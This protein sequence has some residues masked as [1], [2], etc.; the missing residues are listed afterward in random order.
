M[1]LSAPLSTGS[2]NAYLLPRH[3]RQHH[4]QSRYSFCSSRRTAMVCL[5]QQPEYMGLIFKAW[6]QE[7]LFSVLY[8]ITHSQNF[9]FPSLKL[10]ALLVLILSLRLCLAM[11]TQQR[12][13]WIRDFHLAAEPKGRKRGYSTG[14]SDW[15]QS[16]RRNWVAAYNGGQEN[17]I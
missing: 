3:S 15:S 11:E 6:K 8:L 9:Y 17:Y 4:F 1:L 12:F 2:Q 13:H 14:L 5:P 10:W 16:P 7:W